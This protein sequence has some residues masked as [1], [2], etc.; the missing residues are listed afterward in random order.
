MNTGIGG[1]SR[2]RLTGWDGENAYILKCFENGGCNDMNTPK[3]D[4]CMHNTAVY[5]KLAQCEDM[6]EKGQMIVMPVPI[7]SPVYIPYRTMELDGT[8][9]KGIDQM[10]LT[11]Y[12]KEGTGEFYTVADDFGGTTDIIPNELCTT[13]DAAEVMLEE[14]DATAGNEQK[15]RVCGCTQDS[16]CPGGCY[17][18]ED[19]L[20]SQCYKMDQRNE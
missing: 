16:A 20:C 6:V 12:I 3:C 5:K 8:V 18:V 17:W 11:G 15:C 7:G 1:N 13:R 2:D 9:A 19:D 4:L 14:I 10:Y